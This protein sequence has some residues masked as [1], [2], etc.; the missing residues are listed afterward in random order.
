M[1]LQSFLVGI[2][3]GVV[4]SMIAREHSIVLGVAI[5]YIL[6]LLNDIRRLAIQQEKR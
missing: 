1:K 5:A 6:I 4:G 2:V 3:A